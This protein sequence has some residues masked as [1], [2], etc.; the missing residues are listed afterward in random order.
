MTDEPIAR[1]VHPTEDDDTQDEQ[2]PRG[3]HG[4]RVDDGPATT[5]P[6]A[7]THSSPVRPDRAQ[8]F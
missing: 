3:R 1:S 7:T 2:R 4:R 8:H 6:N 5:H